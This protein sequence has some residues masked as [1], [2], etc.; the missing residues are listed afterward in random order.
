M[1]KPILPLSEVHIKNAKRKE[2]DYKLYD[3]DGLYLI[4]WSNPG[5]KKQWRLDYRF[6]GIRKT[7]SLGTYPDITL[8]QVRKLKNNAKE[9]LTN[10]VDPSEER[11]EIKELVENRT[12]FYNVSQ[13]WIHIHKTKITE[14]TYTRKLGFLENHVYPTFKNQTI[15]SI[16]RLNVIELINKIQDKGIIETADR[17]L[18]MLDNIWKYAVTMEMVPHNIIVDIDKKMIMKAKEK[19]EYK[20]LLDPKEVGK[21]LIAL[22]DYRGDTSTCLALRLAPHVFLRSGNI[23]MLKWDWVDFDRK[24][25]T[26]PASDMKMKGRSDF[27]IPLSRQSIA[28]LREAFALSAHKSKYVFPSAISNLK[29][30]SDNTLNYALKRLGYTSNEAVFHGFRKTASTLLNEH[31]R[32]HKI[33][34]VVIEKQLAHEE[35]NQ[36]KRI[37]DKAEYLEERHMLMQ[38]W[39]DYLDSLI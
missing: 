32:I 5:R 16:T 1:G 7:I 36:I 3:G 29:T 28:I 27:I 26:I 18:N 12:S 4:V 39:S 11:K 38:W 22:N 14:G 33:D 2:K 15:S 21:L 17:I 23:R 8:A 10:G 37:Y 9:K 13:A 24:E 34:S 25:I 35:Q 20:G 31:R 30:L 6:Q 19:H